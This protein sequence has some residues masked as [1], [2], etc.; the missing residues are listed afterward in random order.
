[1]V[2]FAITITFLWSSPTCCYGNPLHPAGLCCT[3]QRYPF[4]RH[5]H[6]LESAPLQLWNPDSPTH[7]ST[8]LSKTSPR[9]P[10]KPWSCSQTPS[11]TSAQAPPSPPGQKT[12]HSAA[13]RRIASTLLFDS[14]T[15]PIPKRVPSPRLGLPTRSLQR[16]LL[17]QGAA[18][19][20]PLA[21]LDWRQVVPLSSLAVRLPRRA[22]WRTCL[23][24][25][26]EKSRATERVARLSPKSMTRWMH[27]PLKSHTPLQVRGF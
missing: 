26:T 13:R 5:S 15:P 4:H 25:Q 1:M 19:R 12:H 10:P 3:L 6:P 17:S 20:C 2:K 27:G 9:S 22:R 7:L 24:N 18:A 16:S 23:A 8:H 11:S 14:A 21:R